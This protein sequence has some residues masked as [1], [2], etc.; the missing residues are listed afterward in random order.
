MVA[1]K[2]QTNYVIKRHYVNKEVKIHCTLQDR[3]RK[4]GKR[5][6]LHPTRPKEGSRKKKAIA[7]YKTERGIRETEKKKPKEGSVPGLESPVRR[8]GD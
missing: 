1:L 4:P 6:P 2:K 8:T 3:K 5:K 7:P